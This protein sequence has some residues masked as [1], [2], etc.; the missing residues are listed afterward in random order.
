MVKW[1]IFLL[2][3]ILCFGP[4]FGQNP[5]LVLR[6]SGGVVETG[7]EVELDITLDNEVGDVRSWGWGVCHDPAL[8]SLVGV[9]M[10]ELV[11]TMNNGDPPD[12]HEFATYPDGWTIRAVISLTGCCPIPPGEGISLYHSTYQSGPTVGTAEL[13]FCDTLGVPP[14]GIYIGI[15]G[16]TPRPF[17][18]N[19]FIEIVLPPPFARG[20]CNQ[21]GTLD[22][23]D[24]IF[25][26][27]YMFAGGEK[28][29]CI[30]AC[31]SNDDGV[32]NIADPIYLLN[33]L[34][35]QGPPLPT[36]SAS[37]GSDPTVD[38]LLCESFDSRMCP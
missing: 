5:D 3:G 16:Q 13:E 34:F 19:G 36:P 6:H 21:D 26:E 1:T 33:W 18:E 29:G 15:E 2:L 38:G 8:V 14:I 35:I 32:L 7:D 23:A 24:V 11:A 20:D 10:S 28:P 31:D 9:E 30:D 25:S 17:T 12:F 27:I 4:T 37:C 22:L